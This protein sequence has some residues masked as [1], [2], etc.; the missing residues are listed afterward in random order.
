MSP[1]PLPVAL[2]LGVTVGLEPA[3]DHLFHLF[4]R[5]AGMAVQSS[6]IDRAWVGQYFTAAST[7]LRS[8]SPGDS[9][10]TSQRDDAPS[11]P[12]TPRGL[13]LAD[14]VPLAQVAV[15]DDA[16]GHA[17]SCADHPGAARLGEAARPSSSGR[18]GRSRAPGVS[19]NVVGAE[20]HREDRLELH[21]GEAAPTHR[22]RP[23]PNGIQLQR[24]GGI[25]LAEGAR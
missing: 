8:A 19:S 11:S 24:V 3:L 17:G 6:T 2:L 25:V 4:T 9:S 7:A 16:V 21:H 23:A 13:G 14:A 12:R 5:Y 18:C 1:R 15:H 10:S 22:W 20:H